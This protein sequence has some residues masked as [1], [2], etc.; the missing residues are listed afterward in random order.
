MSSAGAEP[1]GA[2]ACYRPICLDRRYSG[3]MS[4]EPV[5]TFKEWVASM[6]RRTRPP[7]DTDVTVTWDGQRLDTKEKALAFLNRLNAEI[8][9]GLTF[10]ESE[11]RRKALE[12]GGR[13]PAA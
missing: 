5:L 13:S 1:V 10:E 6:N 9:A 4:A 8:A 12:A 3:G 7:T 11:R 2:A